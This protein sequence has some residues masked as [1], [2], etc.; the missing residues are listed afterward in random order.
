[1]APRGSRRS[2]RT[3]VAAADVDI[4]ADESGSPTFS[5]SSFSQWGSDAVLPAEETKEQ[6]DALKQRLLVLA[7]STNRG[8]TADFSTRV[9]AEDLIMQLEDMNPTERPAEA[10]D[11]SWRLVY[12]SVEVFRSSPFFW[13]FQSGI[14]NEE[15]ASQVLSSPAVLVQPCP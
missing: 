7:A 13:A 5:P 15:L 4:P 1:M 9:D 3:I 8:Q 6:R 14:G 10:L 11:G 12:S 2:S